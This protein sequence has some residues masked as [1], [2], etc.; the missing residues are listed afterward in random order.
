VESG[1]RQVQTLEFIRI[2]EALEVAPSE[3]MNQYVSKTSP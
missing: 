3:A 2:C 1:E